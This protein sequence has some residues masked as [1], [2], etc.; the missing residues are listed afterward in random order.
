MKL[1]D[2]LRSLLQERRIAAFSTLEPD[3]SPHLTAVW[4]A[5]EGEDLL[6]AS[7]SRT[8]KVRNVAARPRVALMVELRAAGMER[9]VTALGRAEVLRG[10]ESRAL[11]RRV[12]ER[13]VRAEAFDDPAIGP[14]FEGLEDVTIRV[15]PER[16]IAWD[17]A[18]LD[19]QVFGGRFAP[20]FLPLATD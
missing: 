2:S 16:W 1:D 14:V 18:E 10:A 13:Y 8:R 17:M 5:L 4:F 20:Y 3:G 9:G 15:R 19:R 12:H 11:N 7:S 6:V